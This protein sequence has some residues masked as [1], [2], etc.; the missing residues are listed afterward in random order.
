M[1]QQNPVELIQIFRYLAISSSFPDQWIYYLQFL[2]LLDIFVAD[3]Y[4]Y[5]C[6]QQTPSSANAV[7]LS[8]Y[9]ETN[10]SDNATSEWT[11]Q[12]ESR[13]DWSFDAFQFIYK[14]LLWFISKNRKLKCY[15]DCFI[16]ILLTF[17]QCNEYNRIFLSIRAS[18]NGEGK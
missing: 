17:L 4:V 9:N 15:V 16:Y 5:I 8:I 18:G 6:L 10:G 7:H 12:K 3:N 13:D 1:V 2:R 14:I 11:V